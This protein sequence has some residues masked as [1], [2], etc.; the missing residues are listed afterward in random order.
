[1]S[2]INS[3]TEKYDVKP[4]RIRGCLNHTSFLPF[5]IHFQRIPWDS[6]ENPTGQ[7]DEDL[8]CDI[9]GLT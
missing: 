9:G 8:T 1:M 3:Q 6:H 7:A 4:E 5:F 2:D